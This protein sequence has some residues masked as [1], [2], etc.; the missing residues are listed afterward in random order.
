MFLLNT[1]GGFIGSCRLIEGCII[2]I[3]YIM[4]IVQLLW[5]V[6]MRN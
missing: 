5:S 1:K 3:G 4:L 2:H 6:I